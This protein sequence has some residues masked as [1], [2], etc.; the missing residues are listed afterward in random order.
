MRQSSWWLD[1]CVIFGL[2]GILIFPLFRANY[3]DKWP[4]IEATFIADARLLQTNWGHHLW[5]PLWYLGT[6]ADYVYPPGLRYG[7]A[8]LSSSLNTSAAHA[9]HILIAL[10]YAFGIAGVYLWA[11][12]AGSPAA[13]ESRGAAWLAAA[14]VALTSP[15]FLILADI[16]GDSPFYVPFRLHVLTTYGEGPHISALAVLPLVWLGAWRRFRGGSIRWLFLSA[17]AAALVVTLNFYGATALAITFPLVAW[18]CFLE[19]GDR[20]IL[21]DSLLI[22]A[23]AYG[24]SAWWLSPSYLQV[25]LR[26]LRL[27]APA[28]NDWSVW[29][30]AVIVA[31]YVGASL[32]IRRWDLFQATSFFEFSGLLFLGVYVLGYRW[33]GFQIAGDSQ[34]LIPEWDLFAILCGVDLAARLWKWHPAGRFSLIS[35]TA[36]L[37]L[38][39]LCFRPSWRYLKHAYTEFR[40]DDQW[41]HRVEYRTAEWLSQRFPDQRVFVS[42]TIRFWYNAWHN[43]QQADGGSQQG[44]LDPFIPTAQWR[45]MYESNP[46]QV[47]N[48]LQA[49]GVDIVV[50]AGPASQEPYKDFKNGTVYDAHFPLLRDDG[51]GNRYYRVP[52]RVPGIVRV[53]DRKKFSAV[54]VIPLQYENEQIRAY[55][56]AIE[57]VPPGGDAPNRAQGRWRGSDA[58]D[59]EVETRPGEALLVQETYDPYWC[60]YVDGQAQVIKRDAAGLMV[61]DLPPGRHSLRLVFETPREISIG[62]A[63]TFTTLVLIVFLGLRR[64]RGVTPYAESRVR[65]APE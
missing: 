38:L 35:R 27:V 63:A 7:V 31:G 44:I 46:D 16:R 8:I 57:A 12:T 32:L 61:M 54:P 36:L 11:R 23:L 14:G 19:G 30:F 34:R 29:V 49:L 52:R 42:G 10:F 33:F 51:E 58:L 9:Y 26:D 25:T 6:R 45:V 53:V 3:L 43:G 47:R 50:V 4:S 13:G 21:R 22:A 39:A 18:A 15:S 55:A 60:A 20:R 1:T 17:G 62:R 37:V 64:N 56:E 5:Q 48:W 41:Q 65:D 2:T 24:L 59:V 28:G 40:L